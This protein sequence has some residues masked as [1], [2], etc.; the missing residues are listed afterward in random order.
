MHAAKYSEWNASWSMPE[1]DWRSFIRGGTKLTRKRNSPGKNFI[2]K[3]ALLTFL[4]GL[5]GFIF[6]SFIIFLWFLTK[7]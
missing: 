3:N 4:H 5:S 7:S 1:A 2:R 6:F